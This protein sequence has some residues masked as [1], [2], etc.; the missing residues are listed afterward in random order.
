MLLTLV[1]HQEPPPKAGCWKQ[2]A[3]NLAA[4]VERVSLAGHDG[5][6]QAGSIREDDEKE[7]PICHHLPQC[8]PALL[9]LHFSLCQYL[10]AQI[11]V[12]LSVLATLAH[13]QPQDGPCLAFGG[14]MYCVHW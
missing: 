11:L 7:L 4:K 1:T 2:Q 13:T 5:V 8:L 14:R 10:P 6:D 3:A 12:T 9:S